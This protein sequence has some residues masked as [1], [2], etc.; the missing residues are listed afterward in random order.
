MVEYIIE[1]IIDIK[2]RFAYTPLAEKR[3]LIYYI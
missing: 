3:C 1:Y 2:V